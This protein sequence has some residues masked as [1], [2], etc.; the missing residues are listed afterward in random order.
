VVASC[1]G[2]GCCGAGSTVAVMARPACC[3]SNLLSMQ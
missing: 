3:D 2:G 1:G